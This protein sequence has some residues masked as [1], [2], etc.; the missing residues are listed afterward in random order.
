VEG[1]QPELA[2]ASDLNCIGIA[3]AHDS[4]MASRHRKDHR[5]TAILDDLGVSQIQRDSQNSTPAS[6]GEPA[7]AEVE[8]E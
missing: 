3:V 4:G 6:H 7:V 1:V 5:C 2:A 8:T